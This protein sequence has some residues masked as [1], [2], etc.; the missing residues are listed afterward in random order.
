MNSDEKNEITTPAALD[1]TPAVASHIDKDGEARAEQEERRQVRRRTVR[2]VTVF[3]AGT[4]IMFA[5]YRYFVDSA[6][7]A[8][9]LFQVGRF[10]TYALQLV[11]YESEIEHPDSYKGQE[12]QVRATLE[13]WKKGEE[14]P[15]IEP[16]RSSD[17]PP[18]TAWERY[19]YRIGKLHEGSGAA[20]HP[21]QGPIITVLAKPGLA[22]LI[23]Q[24]RSALS[25]ISDDTP[26]A[27]VQRDALRKEIE[28]LEA[29][30]D[31]MDKEALDKANETRAF[32]FRIVPE[33]G[34]IEVMAIFVAA[35]LAFPAAWTRR[36]VGIVLGI[37]LLMALNVI[38]LTCLALLGAWDSSREYFNFAHEYVWQGIYI[39]FVLVIW[40]AWVEFIVKGKRT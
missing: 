37:P 15:E 34:A 27:E 29:E 12:K 13:A 6:A 8:W 39:I 14:P 32:V 2:F 18:L 17:D 10:T 35:I 9:Y 1:D 33:C 40:L 23:S 31:G 11:T 7:N 26:N 20:K 5:A 38:R 19:R 25:E 21:T 28:T 3:I 4:F 22:Y 30:R 36:L 24:K 16:D